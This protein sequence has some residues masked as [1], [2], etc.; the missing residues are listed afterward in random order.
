MGRIS[1][2]KAFDGDAVRMRRKYWKLNCDFFE[3]V[4]DIFGVDGLDRSP[5]A[6]GSWPGLGLTS[7][8]HR[9]ALTGPTTHPAGFLKKIRLN[10]D[11]LEVVFDILGVSGVRAKRPEGS[12]SLEDSFAPDC[13]PQGCCA[14]APTRLDDGRPRGTVPGSL[15]A[16]VQNFKSN[17]TREINRLRQTRGIPVWQ[18]NYYERVIRNDAELDR[19]RLYIQDNPRRWGDDEENPNRTG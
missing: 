19:I 14:I 5:H 12:E 18:R 4:F 15:G 16:I 6:G 1:T 11:F 8:L 3:V 7:M 10:C 2:D 17:T 9:P 13:F